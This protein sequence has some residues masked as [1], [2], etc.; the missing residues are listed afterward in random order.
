MGTVTEM[1]NPGTVGSIV[2]DEI[3]RGRLDDAGQFVYRYDTRGVGLDPSSGI[4]VIYNQDFGGMA[5]DK[6]TLQINDPHDR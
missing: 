3:T 5:G 4:A 2:E 1:L 6:G